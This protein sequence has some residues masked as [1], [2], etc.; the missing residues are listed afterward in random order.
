MN[1]ASIESLQESLMIRDT[2]LK[3]IVKLYDLGYTD[4]QIIDELNFISLFLQSVVN[5]DK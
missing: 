1:N 4:E 2:L 5:K 3:E